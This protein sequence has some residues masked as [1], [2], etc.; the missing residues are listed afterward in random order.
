MILY[1]QQRYTLYFY[2]EQ[3]F[4]E[5]LIM[6]VYIKYLYG[7]LR[8]RGF[9]LQSYCPTLLWG[10]EYKPQR[11]IRKHCGNWG[12]SFL[13]PT[14]RPSSLLRSQPAALGQLE[15]ESV[16][17]LREAVSTCPCAPPGPADVPPQHD[18]HPPQRPLHGHRTGTARLQKRQGDDIWTPLAARGDLYQ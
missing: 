8:Y 14:C 10:T 4:T 12:F 13:S 7:D 15:M 1:V 18:P 11:T 6:P 3:Y 2:G 17:M 16:Q 5:T 9:V